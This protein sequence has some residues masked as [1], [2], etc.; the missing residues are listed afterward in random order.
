[1]KSKLMAIQRIVAWTIATLSVAVTVA[2]FVM[3][4]SASSLLTAP[5]IGSY[6]SRAIVAA[7]GILAAMALSVWAYGRISTAVDRH[8]SAPEPS[9]RCQ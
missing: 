3:M 2:F 4:T 1:M 9:D 7:F 8:R 5:A 6:G